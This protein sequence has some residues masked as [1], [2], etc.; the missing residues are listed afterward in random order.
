MT[1]FATA[2]GLHQGS[3]DTNVN[4]DGTELDNQDGLEGTRALVFHRHLKNSPKPF[5]NSVVM[6][7]ARSR[8]YKKIFMLSSAEHKIST[9]H[10]C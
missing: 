5:Y 1:R 3:G 9:A 7:L 10:K 4:S 6:V 2:I 8:D